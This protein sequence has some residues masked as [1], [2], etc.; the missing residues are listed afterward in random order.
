MMMEQADQQ[1]QQN[2]FDI[3]VLKYQGDPFYQQKLS[4][5]SSEAIALHNKQQKAIYRSQM[6]DVK[7]K[8]CKVSNPLS[9]TSDTQSENTQLSQLIASSKKSKPNDKLQSRYSSI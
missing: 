3:G 2:E 7:E 5:L 8:L 9:D 1:K 4:D 6:M